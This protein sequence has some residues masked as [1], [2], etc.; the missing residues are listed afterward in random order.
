MAKSFKTLLDEMSQKRQTRIEERTQDLL[1]EIALPEL[2][3]ARNPTQEQLA[4][5]LGL[6][7]ETSKR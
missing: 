7:Q 1:I 2:R 3:Q 5:T 4:Q 6:I